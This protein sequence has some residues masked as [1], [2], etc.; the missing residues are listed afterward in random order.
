MRL[1]VT[2]QLLTD[3]GSHLQIRG[4]QLDEPDELLA[5]LE[6]HPNGMLGGSKCGTRKDSENYT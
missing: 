3:V 2:I 6:P 1:L 5:L 4:C